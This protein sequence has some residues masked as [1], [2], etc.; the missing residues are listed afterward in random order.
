MCGRYA[1]APSRADAWAPVGEVLGKRVEDQLLALQPR[2]NIAPT[3]QV[4]ILIQDRETREL[5]AVLARWGFIPQWWSQP[6]P[7]TATINARSEEAIAKPT[8][9]DAWRYAR[10]LI[11]ATHW[12]EWQEAAEGK[13][14]HALSDPAGYGFMFAG[15][16][17]WRVLVPG[18]EPVPT[19]AIITRDAPLPPVSLVHD[20][21]PAILHPSKWRLWLD[22]SLTDPL[23]VRDIL[24][25]HTQLEART[26]RISRA[27]NAARND[28]PDILVESS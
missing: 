8:W 27:V 28:G 24:L 2:Y 18:T 12:Y 1:V 15:L 9:R 26:W 17:S 22:P 19:C 11:P 7:P 23:V 21:M 14:P 10:C 16:Y 13:I 25:K 6:K 4:P 5:H 20:R 3:A